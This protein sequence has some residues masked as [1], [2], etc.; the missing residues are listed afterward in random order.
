MIK[1]R[2][3]MIS[4]LLCLLLT[5]CGGENFSTLSPDSGEIPVFD[6]EKAA[7][8]PTD[9]ST[10]STPL[11]ADALAEYCDWFSQSCSV[12]NG[13]LRFPYTDGTDAAQIAPYLELLFY[14]AGETE[15]SDTEYT[16]LD[17]AGMFLDCD[18][19]RLSRHF[20]V[21][22]LTTLLGMTSEDANAILTGDVLG[23]YLPAWDAW[24][25]GHGDIAWTP[26]TFTHGSYFAETETVTLYYTN[27]FLTT[28]NANGDAA[29]FT[30]EPMVVTLSIEGGTRCILANERLF[31]K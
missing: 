1:R 17:E 12:Q 10:E 21:S 31:E 3:Q 20:V 7:A 27:P 25:M 18:E 13:V 9:A 24:Y 16:L 2:I 8:P 28:V 4:L 14:D 11:S 29:F 26:Y 22:S 19:F 15:L 5:A 23:V 6:E 30:D